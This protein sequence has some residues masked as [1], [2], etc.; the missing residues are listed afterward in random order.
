MDEWKNE[1][2]GGKQKERIKKNLRHSFTTSK[3]RE[4]R[5]KED[6]KYFKSKIKNICQN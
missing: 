3:E 4:V 2:E 5:R 6:L 1:D